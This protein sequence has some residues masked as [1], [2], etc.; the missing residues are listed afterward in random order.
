VSTAKIQLSSSIDGLIRVLT[1]K[2][3]S[4]ST[5]RLIHTS[6]IARR[7]RD[8]AKQDKSL[9]NKDKTGLSPAISVNYT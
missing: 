8:A 7:A 4:N 2:E 5:Q 3:S 1:R 6:E 9:L